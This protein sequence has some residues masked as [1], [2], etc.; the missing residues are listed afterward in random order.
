MKWL[1]LLLVPFVVVS[2][3]LIR[4]LVFPTLA[5]HNS[6]IEV[7]P[8]FN[9]VK[10]WNYGVSFGMF[11]NLAYGQ[12]LLSGVAIIITILLLFWL[13]KAKSMIEAVALSLV[14]SGAI[15]NIIDRLYFGAVA[16]YLDFHAFGYHWP[17]FN[18]TDT[19]IF[20]GVCLLLLPENFIKRFYNK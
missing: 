4:I 5:E 9:L 2:H 10:V 17:S 3:Q 8:F 16:D 11:N 1:W 12:W 14:I 19:A 13:R 18:L 20:I 6:S 7:L 15:G